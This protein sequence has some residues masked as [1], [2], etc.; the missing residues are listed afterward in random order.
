[1]DKL[2]AFGATKVKA[3]KTAASAKDTA[4]DVADAA[5]DQASEAGDVASTKAG[6]AGSYVNESKSKAEDGEK[7]LGRLEEVQGEGFME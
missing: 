7:G 5:K 4:S 2:H 1:V 6:D 3:G